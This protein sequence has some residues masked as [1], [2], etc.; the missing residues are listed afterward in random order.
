MSSSILNWWNNLSFCKKKK[1]EWFKV[2]IKEG[3]KP[4][5]LTEL[6]WPAD[7]T[8]GNESDFKDSDWRYKE[9]DRCERY[10]SWFFHY[11]TQRCTVKKRVI[12]FVHKHTG[13]FDN[14]SHDHYCTHYNVLDDT[15]DWQCVPQSD[16]SF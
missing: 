14:L 15:G 11:F 4:H 10:V 13:G 5:M 8:H 9:G 12:K 7:V 16:L 2:R 3:Q 6:S 1:E